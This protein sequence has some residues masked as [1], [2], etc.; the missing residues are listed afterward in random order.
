MKASQTISRITA[1]SEPQ[2]FAWLRKEGVEI[3]QAL[4]GSNWTDYNYHDPGV[5]ILE[6]VCFTLTDLIYRT[7]F[8]VA[9]YLCDE[10]G[11]IDMASLGL[12]SPQ[13]VFFNRP[14][15]AVDLQK[16]LLDAAEDISGVTVS[17]SGIG[18]YGLYSI[19][20]RGSVGI[21]GA[22]PDPAVLATRAEQRFHQVRNLCEDLAEPITVV[23]EIECDL[24]ASIAIRPGHAPARVLA[25][26]YFHAAEELASEVSYL[27]FGSGLDAGQGL[28][29]SLQGPFIRHG[30]LAD[31]SLSS[32]SE[33]DDLRLLESSILARVRD[34]DGVEMVTALRLRCAAEQVPATAERGAF[35]YR[36]RQP[37]A[38]R[39]LPQV[40]LSASGR[41]IAYSAEEFLAQLDGLRYSQSRK[42]YRLEDEERISGAPRGKYRDLARYQT[43]QNHFPNAYGINRFG[44]PESYPAERKAQAL[45]LKTYLLLFEQI[46]ANY[47]ANLG[48]I[49]QLF[50]IDGQDRLSYFS[51]VLEADEISSLEQ[52]YPDDATRVLDAILAKVDNFINRKSRLLDYLLALYGEE[53][54]QEQLRSFD[55]YH[56][57]DELNRQIIVNKI[58]LLNRIRF[59]GGDRGA[60]A[61]LQAGDQACVDPALVD[62]AMG[63]GLESASGLQYRTSIFLGFKHLL[64][65]SLV[66]E[67]F[68]YGLTVEDDSRAEQSVI[69]QARRQAGQAVDPDDERYYR[70]VRNTLAGFELFADGSLPAAVLH[71]GIDNSNYEA[72]DNSLLLR[73][74]PAAD[75]PENDQNSPE[76]VELLRNRSAGEIDR[77]RK[78]LHRCL[79]HL[80]RECEG[81]HVLEHILLRPA[82]FNRR[83]DAFR[84]RFANRVSVLFP[85]WTARCQDPQFRSLAEETVRRNCP[86]HVQVDVHWLGFA[87]MCRFEVLHENWRSLL[88]VR[89]DAQR[90]DEFARASFRLLHFLES[91]QARQAAFTESSSEFSLLRQRIHERV[92]HFLAVLKH[93]RKELQYTARRDDDG[94]LDYLRNLEVLEQE[95]GQLDI[96]AIR[97]MALL[98]ELDA[99]ADGEEIDPEIHLGT[100]SIMLPKLRAF[101]IGN[102]THNHFNRLQSL[103]ETTVQEAVDSRWSLRFHWLVPEDLRYVTELHGQWQQSSSSAQVRHGKDLLGVAQNLAAQ[104]QRTADTRDWT[105]LFGGRQ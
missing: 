19:R 32:P 53:F 21:D 51:G 43:L 68:R 75:A 48:S 34:L 66:S 82:D 95:A 24:Q 90:G 28:D 76:I 80:S 89:H 13:D 44:V 40:R 78:F 9:D 101:Q 79:V 96:L 46:M 88:A 1:D 41:T 85:A 94:E 27:A 2:G 17:S 70:V 93:R 6:Q 63:Y 57:H 16:V 104:Q 56:S 42:T 47:L 74:A 98:A 59:A 55:C 36:L 23:T 58:R 37:D 83:S 22:L 84:Q 29:E 62:T 102:G 86:A 10:R 8:D 65:R 4:S 69:D 33:A 99:D 35:A 92:A 103:L 87:D 3:S 81:M 100:V 18:S 14:T 49:R 61:N 7:S 26:V 25:E 54:Q 39:G 50:S 45:Q 71:S 38:E 31:S 64:P 67:V 60:A 30:L 72:R 15:T 97:H 5:T 20:L 91:E 73:L 11:E 52:V 105:R 77:N 12:H